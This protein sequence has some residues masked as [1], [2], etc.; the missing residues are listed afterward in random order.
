MASELTVDRAIEVLSLLCEGAPP[1]RIV[2]EWLDEHENVVE[3][4]NDNLQDWV[5]MNSHLGWALTITQV[6]AAVAIAEEPHD[7]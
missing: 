7:P 5:G 6:E 2:H 3:W 1:R 4:D